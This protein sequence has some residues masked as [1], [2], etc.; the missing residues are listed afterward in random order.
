MALSD[1]DWTYGASYRSLDPSSYVSSPTSL[2]F[3]GGSAAVDAVLCRIPETLVLPQGQI[4][5]WFK[6]GSWGVGNL[7]ARNQKPLGSSDGLNM[8][9]VT[10][11]SEA[12]VLYSVVNNSWSSKGSFPRAGV[13]GVWVKIRFTWWNGE[14]LSGTPATCFRLEEE[15]DG[16][17]THL[18]SV[19]YDTM[20]RWKDSE[21]NRCGVAFYVVQGNTFWFDD[22]EILAPTA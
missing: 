1:W 22:T 3:L 11:Q 12:W 5:T 19:I 8:Y 17:W 14:N 6:S 9:C 18:G 10:C 2:K 15:I 4:V 20:Q 16:V 7:V 21:V 13:H